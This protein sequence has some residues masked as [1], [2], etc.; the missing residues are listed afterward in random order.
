MGMTIDD[1]YDW[2]YRLKSELV[3]YM[4]KE[5]HEY[6]RCSIQDAITFSRKYQML[7]ADYEN[8][9]KND[10]VAMLTDIQLE[11]EEKSIIDYDEALYD[12]GECVISISEI[13]DIIQ[14]K[15]SSIKED[16]NEIQC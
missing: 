11:I 5:W 7:K 15:I 9:L 10:M 8:R 6:M 4:P 1:M 2:L 14:Q 16:K 13:N 12:G 3:V